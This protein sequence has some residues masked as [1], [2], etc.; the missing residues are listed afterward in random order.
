MQNIS[1]IKI[2][3]ITENKMKYLYIINTESYSRDDYDAFVIYAEST[4]EARM[5]LNE[6]DNYELWD[7]KKSRFVKIGEAKKSLK[8]WVV[9]WS[10]NAW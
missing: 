8:K 9:L 4:T 1:E 7:F 2:I 10:F 5:F 6:H 3:W